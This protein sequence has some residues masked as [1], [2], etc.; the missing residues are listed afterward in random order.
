VVAIAGAVLAAH[1]I[2]PPP[3]SN[4]KCATRTACTV[5]LV[6]IT[7]WAFVLLYFALK[8]RLS[9]FQSAVF[10]YNRFYAGNLWRNVFAPLSG[11]VE[12]V[13]DSLDPVSVISIFG[14]LTTFRFKPRIGLIA[15]AFL[16]GTWIAISM[17]GQFYPHYYQLWMPAFCI[18][19]GLAIASAIQFSERRDAVWLSHSAAALIVLSLV[20]VQLPWYR[21]ASDRVWRG[22][23]G[24][25]GEAT[26]LL[27]EK[28]NSKLL[29]GETVF[30]WGQDPAIYFLTRRSP[31]A[32]I[33]LVRHATAGP[34]ALEISTRST[35]QLKRHP[36]DL[37]IV[38]RSQTNVMWVQNPVVDFFAQSYVPF[39]LIQDH[40]FLCFMLRGGE[41]EKRYQESAFLPR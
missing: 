2:L 31:A 1:V 25:D 27:A 33:L 35:Q 36:P 22:F 28:V 14:A 12:L 9:D 40:N 38:H 30:Q 7:T 26:Q 20:L 4:R 37:L 11:N 34:I 18:C 17:P 24:D 39:P 5:L 16:A 32:G 21:N 10:T 3:E 6:G 15:L 13:P 29:A 23:P 41:L 8:G 19:A